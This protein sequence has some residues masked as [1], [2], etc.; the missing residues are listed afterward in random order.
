MPNKLIHDVRTNQPICHTLYFMLHSTRVLNN[1]V[2]TTVIEMV[3]ILDGRVGKHSVERI[4]YVNKQFIT[5]SHCEIW[6]HFTRSLYFHLPLAYENTD[7]TRE[8][9]DAIHEITCH[10]SC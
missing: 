5:L 3:E 2:L 7:V 10:I 8:N 4:R 6:R 9:T 1:V